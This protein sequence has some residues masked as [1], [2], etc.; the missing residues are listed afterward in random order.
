MRRSQ[1]IDV[2]PAIRLLDQEGYYSLS[3]VHASPGAWSEG[4]I[5]T[6]SQIVR[7]TIAFGMQREVAHVR[8]GPE[9]TSSSLGLRNLTQLTG[10]DFNLSRTRI[11]L[12]LKS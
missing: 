1:S 3:G 11:C 12:V 6:C 5:C 7:D 2:T 9:Q 4:P 10:V 8:Y